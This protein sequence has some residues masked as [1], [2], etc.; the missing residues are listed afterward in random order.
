MFRVVLMNVFISGLTTVYADLHVLYAGGIVSLHDWCCC[1]LSP[2]YLYSHFLSFP[3]E[4][5]ANKME[6]KRPVT[7]IEVSF[8]PDSVF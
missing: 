8:L 4:A 1:I 3:A 7:P 5:E 2:P 6:L